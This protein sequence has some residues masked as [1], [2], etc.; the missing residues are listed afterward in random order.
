M[1]GVAEG[2]GAAYDATVLT[3]SSTE[4]LRA[5]LVRRGDLP[6]LG[7]DL[8]DRYADEAEAAVEAIEAKL[9]GMK[10]SLA[11]A[12]AEAKRLRAEATAAKKASD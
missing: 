2:N 5:E 12:K 6:L 9:A 8:L 7:Q 10:E 3:T 4:E 1:T 11:T